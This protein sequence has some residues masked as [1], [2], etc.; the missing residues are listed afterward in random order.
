MAFEGI[1]KPFHGFD[2]GSI[3]FFID[4]T[5]M[6]HG[7]DIFDKDSIRIQNGADMVR[8]RF[9]MDSSLFDADSP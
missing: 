1:K 9:N 7:C 3:E 2:P 6:R 5:R 8:R 4:S